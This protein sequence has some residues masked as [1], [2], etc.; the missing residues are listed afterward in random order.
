M[1]ATAM[2]GPVMQDVAPLAPRREVRIP[3]DG[4]VVVPVRRREEHLRRADHRGDLNGARLD[5]ETSA[6]PITP[7]SGSGVP[8]PAVPEVQDDPA[9]W[10]AAFFARALGSHEPDLLG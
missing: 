6:A 10:S 1:P 7:S 4:R 9:V 3:V 8:P 2:L 5:P